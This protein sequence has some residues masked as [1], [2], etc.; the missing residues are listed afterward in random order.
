MYMTQWGLVQK[1]NEI[2]T[3]STLKDCT[4]SIGETNA[5]IVFKCTE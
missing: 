4:V 2:E 5:N 3:L 1:N